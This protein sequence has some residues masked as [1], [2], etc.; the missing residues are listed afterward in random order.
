MQI[1]RHIA[2][3]IIVGL[4][5]SILG[6]GVIN[7]YE[8][9]T[10]YRTFEQNT[11]DGTKLVNVSSKGE[12][13]NIN[14]V[15]GMLGS[16]KI[17]E[18]NA[19]YSRNS[20][21]IKENGCNTRLSN[22]KINKDNVADE[23]KKFLQN[24]FQKLG[25]DPNNLRVHNVLASDKIFVV[26]FVQ[27]IDGYDIL[28]SFVRM[29]VYPDG[30]IQTFSS[31]YYY[32]VYTHSD[33][34]NAYDISKN[35]SSK[36]I[37]RI[38]SSATLGLDDKN[39]SY[40][41]SFT[42]PTYV[43][44]VFNGSGYD[45]KPVIEVDIESGIEL[46][47]SYIDVTNYEL[48]QRKN[49]VWEANISVES[50]HYGISPNSPMELGPMR[51]LQIEIEGEGTKTT[52]NSGVISNLPDNVIGK[53]F[54]TK[55]AGS[56]VVMKE[57]VHPDSTSSG[58]D[59]SYQGVITNDGI[60]M[61]DSNDYD[62]VMRTIY[63]NV[64]TVRNYYTLM[65][66]SPN[67]GKQVTAIAQIIKVPANLENMSL[68][69]NAY[70]SGDATLAFLCAN[71]K[72][73]F[74]GKLDK[75]CY[76]EY[77]HSIVFAKYVE[78]N[79]PTGMF[80]SMANEANADITAAFIKDDPNVFDGIVKTGLEG[81]ALT[82]NLHR[83]CENDYL[84]TTNIIGESHEDSQI[85]SGAFWDF[86]KT[87]KD[88][89][90][91]K[92]AVHFAKEYLPD[93]Y[94]AEEVFST[95]FDAMV[96]AN[97]RYT[98]EWVIDPNTGEYIESDFKEF[99]YNFNE[100]YRAFNKHKIGFNMLINNR[101][102]HSNVPDQPNASNSMPISCEILDF[103]APEY[104]NELYVNYYTNFNSEVKSV[105]LTRQ[106]SSNGS[107][108]TGEIPAQEEGSRVFYR[109]TYRDPFSNNIETIDRDYFFFTGY[110]SLHSNDCN[111]ANGWSIRHSANA[112]NGWS[113]ASPTVVYTYNQTPWSHILYSPGY[114]AIGSRCFTT[115]ATLKTSG[116]N[117]SVET[118]KDSSFVESPTFSFNHSHIFLTYQKWLVCRVG[119]SLSISGLFVE[120]SFDGG[121]TWRLVQ[122]FR[123][124][125]KPK[126]WEWQREYI[127]LTKFKQE[128]ED[129][130]NLKV[131]FVCYAN[132]NTIGLNAL[133]DDIA[134]LGTNN[135]DKIKEA[136]YINELYVSPNPVSNEA[137]LS[138]PYSVLN[139][140]ISISSALGNEILN[141]KLQG[142]YN[143]SKINT[144]D[145]P[146]GVYFVKVFADDKIYQ[147]KLVIVR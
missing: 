72:N 34:I 43:L 79:K 54:T 89:D 69:F 125:Q 57:R 29:Y 23:C 51:N 68:N 11:S 25:I 53:K 74:M 137:T 70:A 37:E 110:D 22:N 145:L 6:A 106:N 7:A 101:F 8:V 95:W 115:T 129:F 18:M 31:M 71:H 1:L 93:G 28:N 92:R 87:A 121:N 130:S 15:Y 5:I 24:S 119:S 19:Q 64:S 102:K 47:K 103:A 128:G 36:D 135:P 90:V 14:E 58:T 32:D 62:E 139:P 13:F 48:L 75:V 118:I 50:K 76:H 111:N 4:S 78:M 123:V 85:L 131:R 40:T 99:E 16:K 108:Y 120:V 132:N 104:I 46:Y 3:C 21:S 114:P 136:P 30:R 122:E 105:L 49:L 63:N 98:P 42:L 116:K 2:M 83:T 45:Y 140:E 86:R 96:R 113:I 138:F 41:I 100:I 91:V 35:L 80:S 33:D 65:D 44:P 39:L 141:V 9:N 112:T 52:T 147:T 56:Y 142:E 127:N 60:K 143:F 133:I 67:V 144:S 109:F 134:L 10:S 117:P 61:H 38:G 126:N 73:V 146:N 27:T 82:H 17:D 97:D 20:A 77:G 124:S 55:L 84:F 88:F 12:V 59:Y 107:I 81:W 26:V 94:T 66:P